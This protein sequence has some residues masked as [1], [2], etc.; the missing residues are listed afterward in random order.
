MKK[1]VKPD[2]I[3][4]TY[5]LSY[6][7]ANCSAALNHM[8]AQNGCAIKEVDGIDLGYT[9]YT[10]GQNCTYAPEIWEDYCK[11]TGTDDINVFTS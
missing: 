7:V 5:E 9:V 11:F 3:Y 4:E 1:Y 8:E 6:N 2:L 10:A